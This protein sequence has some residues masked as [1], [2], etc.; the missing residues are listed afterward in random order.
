[1]ITNVRSKTLLSSALVS[2]LSLFGCGDDDDDTPTRGNLDSGVTVGETAGDA[3]TDSS[4]PALGALYAV[5]SEVY[6]PDFMSST[7][8][9]PV[10]PSLDVPSIS[11]DKAREVDGRAS[12][13]RIGKYVF[14]ASAN[15]PIANR[16]VVSAEGVLQPD[17]NINFSNEG[18]PPYF[19]IDTFG[20]LFV[21]ETKAYIFNGADGSM[22]VWNPTTLTITG[23]IAGPGIVRAGYEIQSSQ[24]VRGN[25]LYRLFSLVNYDAW[26][27][28]TTGQVLV[29]YDLDTDTQLSKV[30]ENRCPQ[31][32]ATPFV[33][34]GGDIYFSGWVWPATLPLVR[35]FPK[36]CALRV[37]A[38]Q[39]T[40]DPGYKLDFAAQL[41]GHEGAMMSYLGNGQALV[42]VFHQERAT[43][44]A[45]S[46][47][48]DLANTKNWRVWK[49]DL[50][51]G[52]GAPLEGLDYTGAGYSLAQVDG[53]SF[54]LSPDDETYS[55]T[56][57]SEVLNGALKPSFK[58]KGST[59][60][61]IRAR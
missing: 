58:I 51:T 31:L 2:A 49:I 47:P 36:S 60:A 26:D 55:A 22:V 41:D 7:S 50:A 28:L 32:Y 40:F 4:A 8:Y 24:A 23:R 19:A 16:F 42:D 61:I 12:V 17:G 1:M 44:D 45:S 6:G 38:G 53:R 18:L 33:T 27:F 46:D 10:V 39:D 43:Y 3:G 57:A 21:S 34:E 13:A 54:L 25:K 35:D 14:I 59:Y 52:K 9:V 11:I 15:A 20:A 37:L 48:Q 56:T 5:P 29:V 30:E